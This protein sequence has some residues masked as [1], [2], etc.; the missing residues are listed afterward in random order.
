MDQKLAYNLFPIVNLL[1]M[2]L[3][4]VAGAWQRT[5]SSSFHVAWCMSI[6]FGILFG[7]ITVIVVDST[8][9]TMPGGNPMIGNHPTGIN[10]LNCLIGA[11]FFG[12]ISAGT[13]LI[14]GLIASLWVYARNNPT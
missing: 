4:V 8:A 9:A 14:S 2:F 11:F 3:G 7:V 13:G 5:V 12:M 1:S 6:V 10:T